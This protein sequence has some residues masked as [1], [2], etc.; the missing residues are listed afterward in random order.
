M[1]NPLVCCRVV[2]PLSHVRLFA[3]PW[4]VAHQAPLSM[5]F[6]RQEYWSGLPFLS[7]GDLSDP[8]I[9]PRSPVLAGRYFTTEPPGKPLFIPC[10]LLCR[11]WISKVLVYS[12]GG[13]GGLVA[14]SCLTLETPE[15][16]G[17]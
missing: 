5:G 8:G 1:A 7:P 10:K 11:E 6:P 12:T 16:P 2:K 3:T 17:L 4:T 15:I 9:K 14:K 13:G